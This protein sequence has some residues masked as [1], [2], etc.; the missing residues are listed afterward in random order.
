MEQVREDV[1][2]SVAGREGRVVHELAKVRDVVGRL[3][4]Q[5]GSLPSTAWV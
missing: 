5:L 3:D 1:E 2:A 4:V